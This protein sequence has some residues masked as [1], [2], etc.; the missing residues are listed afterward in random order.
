M[1]NTI[2]KNIWVSAA[3]SSYFNQASDLLEM[4]QSQLMFLVLEAHVM[5]KPDTLRDLIDSLQAA[6][7]QGVGQSPTVSL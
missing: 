2:R 1:K 5:R 7:G 3:V 6:G 4:S